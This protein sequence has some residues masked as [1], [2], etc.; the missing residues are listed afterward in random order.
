MTD[1][2]GSYLFSSTPSATPSYSV[3]V[4]LLT[5]PDVTGTFVTTKSITHDS[6]GL[7]VEDT[8][9]GTSGAAASTSVEMDSDSALSTNF[10]PADAVPNTTQLCQDDGITSVCI[11]NA[12][13]PTDVAVTT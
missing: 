13:G 9:A 10:M 12:L 2:A 5:V 6:N 7:V 3:S 4:V 11:T 1:S 8:T